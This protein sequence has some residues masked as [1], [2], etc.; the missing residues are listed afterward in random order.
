[1]ELGVSET[2]ICA[3]VKSFL[4]Q[5]EASRF[6]PM[7]NVEKFGGVF[8]LVAMEVPQARFDEVAAIVNGFTE[9]AHNY[10]REHRWNMW[11]VTATE[12]QAQTD[13]VL[14]AIE[15]QT[16]LKCWPMPK[17]EEYFLDLRFAR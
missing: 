2:D 16:G 14:G 10:E 17:L 1:M 6:G 12:S 4:E 13:S 7:F 8:T 11:F 15:L 5:K 9:V 3:R